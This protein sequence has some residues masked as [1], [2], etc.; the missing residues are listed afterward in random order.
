MLAKRDCDGFGAV[1]G[2]DFLEERDGVLP[3]GGRRYA[4]L[5][6]DVAV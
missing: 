3:Y 5:F 6:C 4:K 1:R 2:A